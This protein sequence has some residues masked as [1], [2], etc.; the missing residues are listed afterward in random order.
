VRGRRLGGTQS[1]PHFEMRAACGAILGRGE[2]P[3]VFADARSRS[4]SPDM[5]ATDSPIWYGFAGRSVLL[6][7]PRIRA[8]WPE[9]RQDQS[10]RF[11]RAICLTVAAFALPTSTV[12]EPLTSSTSPVMKFTVLQSVGQCRGQQANAKINFSA[13]RRASLPP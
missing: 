10:P 8:L 11:D 1:L 12:R 13:R 6:A 3:A 4:S 2:A 9:G 5:S 7:Q